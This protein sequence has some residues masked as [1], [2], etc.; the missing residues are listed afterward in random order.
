MAVKF[1]K[2]RN[3]PAS[4]VPAATGPVKTI[5]E[6]LLLWDPHGETVPGRVINP[7]PKTKVPSVYNSQGKLLPKK[8]VTTP[9][10]ETTA[11][12]AGNEN[13]AISAV[14]AAGEVKLYISGGG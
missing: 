12:G 1:D 4:D 8:S 11:P 3:N 7:L 9:D 6:M 5:L 2:F 10:T 13:G 14:S